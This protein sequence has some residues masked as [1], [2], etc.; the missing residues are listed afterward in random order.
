MS[1][2]RVESPLL[3]EFRRQPSP[4][5]PSRM[6]KP[7]ACRKLFPVDHDETNRVLQNQLARMREEQRKEYGFDFDR[8]EP[9]PN[10]DGSSRYIDWEATPEERVSSFYHETVA[11]PGHRHSR[12]RPLPTPHT[13]QFPQHRSSENGRPNAAICTTTSRHASASLVNRLDAENTRT[14]R[15]VQH[16]DLCPT[17]TN[18]TTATSP[19]PCS[20]PSS[21]SESPGRSGTAGRSCATSTNVRTAPTQS[22]V[23][24]VMKQRKRR[25]S[26]SG[27]TSSGSNSDADGGKHS[28]DPAKRRRQ[29]PGSS[30]VSHSTTGRS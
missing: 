30:S 25:R 18:S 21:S 1:S 4:S 12:L 14:F 19:N 13:S 20:T 7:R 8:G 23:T 27:S 29:L 17:E 26:G 24:D 28:H 2:V 5:C 10:Q 22:Q 15:P 16:Q 3:P 6:P 9:L 11:R